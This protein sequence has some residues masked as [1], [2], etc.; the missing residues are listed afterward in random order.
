MKLKPLLPT[1]KEKKRYVAFEV[2]TTGTL[3]ASLAFDA[4][5]ASAHSFVGTRGLAQ[6]GLQFFKEYYNPTTKRGV[7]RVTHTGLDLLRASMALV[8]T[9]DGK[10][11]LMRSLGA[12]GILTKTVQYTGGKP[13]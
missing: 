11:A 2:I 5:Y 4:L 6:L 12:S 8:T 3:N 13:W 9:I 7:V 1:L 10:P